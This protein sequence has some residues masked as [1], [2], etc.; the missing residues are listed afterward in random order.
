MAKGPK[1]ATRNF[2]L[3][4]DILPVL[5]ATEVTANKGSDS[6]ATNSFARWR[7]PSR[8][9]KRK[10][11]ALWDEHWQRDFRFAILEPEI[12]EMVRFRQ[13]QMRR[14]QFRDDTLLV[15]RARP[16]GEMSPQSPTPPPERNAA[17][18]SFRLDAIHCASA[19]SM[20]HH[21]LAAT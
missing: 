7:V 10:V 6:T 13:R 4:I 2:S 18:H 16:D 5:A 8:S 15:A 19:A 9:R 12:R 1:A 14:Y 3:M 17:Q 20:L 11:V 21:R